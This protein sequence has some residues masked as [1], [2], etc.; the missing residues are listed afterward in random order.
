VSRLKKYYV[1]GALLA[2]LSLW[3]SRT[4]LLTPLATYVLLGGLPTDGVDQRGS[5]F[6]LIARPADNLLLRRL[7]N[8]VILHRSRAVLPCAINVAG[9]D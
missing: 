3:A 6:F 5:K 8:V 7:L 1:G 2:S 4:I 9:P